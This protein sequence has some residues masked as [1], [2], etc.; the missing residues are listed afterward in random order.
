[1]A[2]RNQK[3]RKAT[4]AEAPRVG[5]R[6]IYTPPSSS[7]ALIGPLFSGWPDLGAIVHGHM[8][9]V[10]RSLFAG[11]SP[12]IS[13]AVMQSENPSDASD[14]LLVAGVTPGIGLDAFTDSVESFRYGALTYPGLLSADKNPHSS[15]YGMVC[16]MAASKG[17]LDV[18][19]EARAIGCPWGNTA[20]NACRNGHLQLLQWA[21][22]PFQSDR[23][24]LEGICYVVA[25]ERGHLDVIKFLR[26]ERCKYR[27][28]SS[29]AAATFGHPRCLELLYEICAEN[30]AQWKPVIVCAFALETGRI[31]MLKTAW[32]LEP[33]VYDAGP[34]MTFKALPMER[35]ADRGRID[36]MEWLLDNG[37]PW[38]S[39]TCGVIAKLG[40]P[41]VSKWA[42]DAPNACRCNSPFGT[43]MT[44][45]C[46]VHG[47][48]WI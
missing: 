22:G 36:M 33:A 21:H 20:E 25:A 35:A 32:A 28:G 23:V 31:D 17:T 47:D 13:D 26:E 2:S 37:C 42:A 15:S 3:A 4:G 11:V 1:M 30:Y 12:S 29:Y 8:D 34:S 14:R 9:P 18:L 46:S 16:S 19:S 10:D 6:A 44:L 48:P 27:G 24:P 7:D 40:D 39:Y 41:A 5:P 43:T 38:G 45:T